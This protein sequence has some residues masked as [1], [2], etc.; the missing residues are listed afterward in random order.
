MVLPQSRGGRGVIRISVIGTGYVGLV[1]AAC[2]AEVGHECVCVDVEASKVD[3]INRGQPT[4]HEEGLEEILGRQ[5]GRRLRATA[6]L[7]AAVLSS[8]IT[9]IAVGTPFDGESIDLTFIR[10]AASQV[11]AALRDK[12]TYHVVVVKSTV[13]PGTTDDVVLPILEK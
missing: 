2:F 3:K 12:T 8:D 4:I 13:V 5:V 11:G 1:S 9:F 6:D 7:R 10:A